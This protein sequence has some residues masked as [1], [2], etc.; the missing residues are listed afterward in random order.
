MWSSCR[1]FDQSF[2]V[3]FILSQA[4]QVGLEAPVGTVGWCTP[5]ESSA[6]YLNNWLPQVF[7][8]IQR[9]AMFVRSVHSARFSTRFATVSMY[10]RGSSLEEGPSAEVENSSN[11]AQAQ[12]GSSST[13]RSVSLAQRITLSLVRT[14]IKDGLK[15]LMNGRPHST[16]KTHALS[17]FS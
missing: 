17:S 12:P 7:F 13:S 16:V 4:H 9:F 1:L 2:M 14:A 8:P 11:K 3:S 6:L 15:S 10:T 5:S